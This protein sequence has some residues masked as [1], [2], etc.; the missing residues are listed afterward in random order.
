MFESH[1][2]KNGEMSRKFGN[3]PIG[4]LRQ[5]YGKD[6]AYGCADNEKLGDMLQNVDE[7]S[8]SKLVKDLEAGKLEGICKGYPRA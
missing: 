2:D 1:R 3:T 8:L 5:H 4:I 7:P 6:F